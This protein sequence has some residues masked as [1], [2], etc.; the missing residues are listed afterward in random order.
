MKLIAFIVLTLLLTSCG[1]RRPGKLGA[2]GKAGTNGTSMGIEVNDVAPGA[3]CFSGGLSLSVFKDINSNGNLEIT[4][5][6]TSIKLVCNGI[7]GSNGT[8]GQNGTNGTNG[9]NGQDGTSATVTLASVDPGS[10]CPTGG[11]RISSNTSPNSQVV[12]NGIAG[13]NGINGM[14]GEDGEDGQDGAQGIQGV[15]GIQGPMGPQGPQ[16]IAGVNGTNGSNGT[17]VVPVKF[18]NTDNST[19]PEYGLMIGTELFAV[20]WGTTPDSPHKEQAFLAKLVPGS[21]HSTGGNGCNFT[22]N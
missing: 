22:I 18:C 4:E 6:V 1:P 12:C 7:N 17:S 5:P 21:Y 10:E 2:E 11:V 19:Y 16:G 20:Y 8:D 9:T 14:N 13:L 3:G 15:P